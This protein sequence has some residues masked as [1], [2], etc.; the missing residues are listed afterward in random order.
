MFWVKPLKSSLSIINNAKSHNDSKESLW[1][2]T[3]FIMKKAIF[4]IAISIFISSGLIANE[5]NNTSNNEV[6]VKKE[7]DKPATKTVASSDTSDKRLASWD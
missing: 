2:V 1:V 7:K 5:K 6:I 4:T 3:K